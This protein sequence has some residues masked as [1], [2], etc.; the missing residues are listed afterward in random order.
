M[1]TQKIMTQLR[2]SG[3]NEELKER[4]AGGHTVRAFCEGKGISK[5]TLYYYRQKKVREA[6][7][8]EL[9]KKQS[10]AGLVPSG[11]IFP[12]LSVIR[13]FSHTYSGC[14]LFHYTHTQTY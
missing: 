5:A 4:I 11:W 3:W 1:D 12:S 8:T 9:L 13:H 7:Y 6:A 10:E 2:L 14:I